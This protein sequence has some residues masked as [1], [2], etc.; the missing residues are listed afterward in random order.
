MNNTNQTICLQQV[1][2]EQRSPKK[3]SSWIDIPKKILN[4]ITRLIESSF[5]W[6]RINE[7]ERQLSELDDRILNDIGLT[8]R[9]ISQII[10]KCVK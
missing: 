5:R 8:R 2:A 10:R 7:T 4:A 9:D 3:L 1:C 6:Y